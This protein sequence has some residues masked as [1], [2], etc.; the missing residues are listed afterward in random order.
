MIFP[1]TRSARSNMAA[2]VNLDALI[3]REDFSVSGPGEAPKKTSIQ[4]RQLEAADFFYESLRKPDFQRDTEEWD[5]KTVAGLI[6]TF[7]EDDLIPAVILWQNKGLCYVIDGAHRLS[8]LIAWVQDDYGDGARSKEFYN[9]VIPDEQ[10]RYAKRTRK[11]VER[12][13]GSYADHLESMRNPELYGPDIVKRALTLGS[14]SLELQ[15]VKGNV[16]KAENSFIR[17]NQR[18]AMITP[19]EL[20]LIE[21]RKQ[22]AVIASR[23]I[24]RRGTGHQYWAKM[25]PEKQEQIKT[26][27][28]E[29]FRLI[30]EPPMP[31]PVTTINL[32][33]GGPVYSGTALRMTFDFVRLC[34]GTASTDEDSTGDHA[35]TYLERTKNVMQ[36]ILS[37]ERNSIGLHPAVYFYSWTAK[38][39]P[40]LFLIFAELMMDLQQ[41]KKL[42]QFIAVREKLEDYLIFNRALVSQVVRKF[43]TKSS[44]YVHVTEFY[45]KLIDHLIAGVSTKKLTEAIR[46]E[47]I[48]K[49][50]QPE[51][52]PYEATPK[53]YSSAMK[54]GIVMRTLLLKELVCPICRGKLPPQCLSFD[55]VQRLQDGGVSSVDNAQ[56]THPYC[57]TGVKEKRHSDEVK[58][59]VAMQKGGQTE[60][61][62]KR[63][64]H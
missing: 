5:P 54:A 4:I 57:N 3:K 24:I 53:A 64:R 35:I 28:D 55:H 2:K 36:F 15:W 7:I 30:F 16:A 49:F 8:A 32:P 31:N 27:G 56:L 18:A 25:V 41:K 50:L 37:S 13:F 48:F 60:L 14:L 63:H 22:P 17:I 1:A 58:A 45:S 44:G 9:G 11:M 43:G 12:E 47:A 29:V 59:K 26:L 39:Q 21:K 19:Q 61:T 51:E 46:A 40:I 52:S 34:V 10:L 6:R 62:R 20:E 33:A 42:S 23:A 38:Q